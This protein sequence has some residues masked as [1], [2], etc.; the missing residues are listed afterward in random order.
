MAGIC[1]H[2]GDEF[3]VGID[4]TKLG[5]FVL[6]IV[7]KEILRRPHLLPRDP[8]VRS[9]KGRLHTVQ[10]SNVVSAHRGVLALKSDDIVLLYCSS[11]AGSL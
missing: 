5:H 10:N 2:H 4:F 6:S 9:F 1:Q 7:S 8:A 3:G 11:F